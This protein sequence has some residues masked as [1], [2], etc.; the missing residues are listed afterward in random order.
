MGQGNRARR[1]LGSG[2]HLVW[3]VGLLNLINYAEQLLQ[4]GVSPLSVVSAGAHPGRQGRVLGELDPDSPSTRV[5]GLGLVGDKYLGLEALN[6]LLE[7]LQTGGLYF[8]VR[9]QY[10]DAHREDVLVGAVVIIQGD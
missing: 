1:S 3:P 10:S 4:C 2:R 9:Q 6:R 7:R 5:L 8:G